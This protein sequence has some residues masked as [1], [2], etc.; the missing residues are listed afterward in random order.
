MQIQI[1]VHGLLTIRV[2]NP[3]GLVTLTLPGL[4]RRRAGGVGAGVGGWGDGATLPSL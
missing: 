4:D 2:T 3:D 1:K